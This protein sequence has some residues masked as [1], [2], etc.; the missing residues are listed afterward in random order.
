VEDD[1]SLSK[2]F[3]DFDEANDGIWFKSSGSEFDEITDEAA[4]LDDKLSS[5][6]LVNEG[7]ILMLLLS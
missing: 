1:A 5:S 6:W 3:F 2:S 7:V 4:C